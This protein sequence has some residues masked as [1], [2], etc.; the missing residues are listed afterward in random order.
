VNP[1]PVSAFII[2][3]NEEAKIRRCLQSISWCAEIVIVDSGSTDKTLEICKEF[4]ERIFTRPWPGFVEQKR[5]ALEQCRSEWVLNI[6]ADEEVSPQLRD[7]I[8]QRLQADTSRLQPDNV[9]GFE[10]LRV[11]FYL[12]K[13]WRKGGWYPEYRLRLCRRSATQ[14]GGEDPHEKAIVSGRRERLQNELRHYTYE[15]ARSLHRRGVRG[16]L[17]NVIANPILRFL[18]FYL[19]KRG[20]LEGRPGFVVACFETYYAFLKYV[21][22]WELERNEK[23]TH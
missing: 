10:L 16:S 3:C 13:W 6:D 17:L 14:W 12:G 22:L 11:V 8:A 7:E 2:C 20:F 1:P 18:K 19:L 21:K 23:S 4:T 5:F 15:A 9:N